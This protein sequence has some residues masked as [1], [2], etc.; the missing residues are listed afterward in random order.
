[1][2]PQTTP[3]L[4]LTRDVALSLGLG[5][6]RDDCEIVDGP[7]QVP[8]ADN[9]LLVAD[10]ASVDLAALAEQRLEPQIL[11]ADVPLDVGES[12]IVLQRPVTVEHVSNAIDE[13]LQIVQRDSADPEPATEP[14]GA[15]EERPTEAGMDSGPQDGSRV[16]DLVDE[17][18]RRPTEPDDD[19]GA[20]AGPLVDGGGTA[21]AVRPAATEQATRSTPL[22]SGE[23]ATEEA[24]SA[25]GLP[26]RIASACLAAD[27]LLDLLADVPILGV[28]AQ[29][30]DMLATETATAFEADAVVL[31][32]PAGE[33]VR[34]TATWGVSD[35]PG[36]TEA[37]ASHPVVLEVARPG[38]ALLLDP[39][40]AVQGAVAGLAGT[41]ARS[42]MAVSLG[43]LGAGHG[44]L[45][46]ARDVPLTEADL[47]RLVDFG[48]EAGAMLRVGCRLERLT[49]RSPA[50]H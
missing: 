46:V 8:C 17:E 13:A 37:P 15:Q 6:L 49:P 26:D 12:T 50:T 36:L 10:L 22:T 1:M 28:P 43:D 38:G 27:V 19:V 29:L 2:T 42:F 11:I 16:I 23:P 39:V 21:T 30:R 18:R 4:V 47:D 41:H 9:R 7:A 31:W 44:M 48:T 24:S 5:Q 35:N 32:E 25:A 40:D 33:G 3:V 20:V 34:A 14:T 45:T